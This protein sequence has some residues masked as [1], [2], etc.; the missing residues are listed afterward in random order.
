[1]GQN[2]I[3]RDIPKYEGYYQASD[4]GNIRSLDREI[5]TKNGH[6]RIYKGRVLSGHINDGYMRT[7]LTKG[8]KGIT[9]SFSQLVAMAF[10]NHEVDGHNNVV[11]HINGNKLDNRVSNLRVVTQ[12]ENLSKCYRSDISSFSSKHIGVDWNKRSSKWQVNIYYRG[13]QHHL[14]YFDDENKASDVYQ[15]A[16]RD[17]DTGK[18]NYDDYKAKFTS[19]YKGVYFHSL[20]K[21]WQAE[22]RINKKKIY[23]GLF[24]TEIEAHKAYESYKL[25]QKIK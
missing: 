23:L 18:F 2:E 21:K 1:M 9:F 15:K 13:K 10:L 8:G 22:I 6:K 12:R 11:D 7:S 24:K 19:V 17:I 14:G 4:I 5:I 3:W 25:N 20:S 16:L